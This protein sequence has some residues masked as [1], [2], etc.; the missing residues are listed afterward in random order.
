MN[1]A[2][3]TP[4]ENKAWVKAFQFYCDDN[5]SIEDADAMAWEDLCEQYPRLKKYDGVKVTK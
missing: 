1:R 5:M 2:T 3:L 4:A